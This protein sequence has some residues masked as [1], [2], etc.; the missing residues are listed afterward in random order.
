MIKNII[1]IAILSTAIGGASIPLGFAITDKVSIVY[2]GN[3]IGSVVSAMFVVFIGDKIKDQEFR[4]KINKRRAG[5]KVIYIFEQGE[6]SKKVLKVKLRVDKHG[7]RLFSFFCSMFPGTL[8]SSIAVYVLDLDRTIFKKW[9]FLGI[10][11]NSALYVFGYWFI[12]VR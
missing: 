5:R 1:I 2:L 11:F 12:F 6:N 3:L 10:L 4:K 9:M 7:L 8:A